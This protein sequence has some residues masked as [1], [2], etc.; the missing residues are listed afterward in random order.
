MK[1]LLLCLALMMIIYA[2]GAQATYPIST[3]HTTPGVFRN[4]LLTNQQ[5]EDNDTI[6]E[7]IIDLVTPM[8]QDSILGRKK[9]HH[10]VFLVGWIIHAFGDYNWRALSMTKQKFVGTIKGDSRSGE[11]EYTEYDINFNLYAHTH[12]Y[13]WKIFEAY[14]RQ[15]K[16]GR[17]DFISKYLRKK[18]RLT[19]YNAVPFVRDTNNADMYQYRMHCELTPQREFR[20][21]LN[22]LFYPT[23]PGINIDK[24]PNFMTSYPS[25]GF[26][27]ASCLDCNHN[28]HPEIHPYEWV[29]WMNL[30]TGSISDKTWLVG[31]MKDGSSRFHHWSHNPKTGKVCIPFSYRVTDRRATDRTI[32]IEHLVFNTFIDSN[33]AKLNLPANVFDASHRSVQVDLMDDKGG[34]IPVMVQFHNVM[35]DSGLRYWFSDVNWDGPNHILS[36]YINMAT[37]VKDVY[38]TRITMSGQ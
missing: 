38:T 4:L 27:G 20:P 9:E 14:D 30:H 33:L 21:M 34:S 23:Q 35:V 6:N 7:E 29:W 17:Q 37:S 11:E 2:V 1:Q 32:T 3:Y 22:Y 24:H 18:K 8:V 10:Q 5:I 31:L 28:C 26:Y 16:A 36:G 12:K 19:D 25:M 15:R 13:L